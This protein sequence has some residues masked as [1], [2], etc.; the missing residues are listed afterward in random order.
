MQ[1]DPISMD[2]FSTSTGNLRDLLEAKVSEC[3]AVICLIGRAFGEPLPATPGIH[4]RSYTQFEFDLAQRFGIPTFLFIKKF[5]GNAKDSLILEHPHQTSFL[6]EIEMSGLVRHPFSNED[7]FR[8]HI[9]GINLESIKLKKKEQSTLPPK[10]RSLIKY[11][12]VI[13]LIL[14]LGC[15]LFP[16]LLRQASS[17]IQPQKAK[18]SSQL[19]GIVTDIAHPQ[20]ITQSPS[21]NV[22][23]ITYEPGKSAR[24]KLSEGVYKEFAWCPPGSF[25]MGFST[26]EAGSNAE[27]RI[28]APS[29]QVVFVE[30]FWIA[31][32]ELTYDEVNAFINIDG[33][34]FPESA[35]KS[36]NTKGIPLHGIS[37]NDAIQL[38]DWLKRQQEGQLEISL[39][40]ECE[41]EYAARAG[42]I[43]PYSFGFE[44]DGTQANC[45]GRS[46][47][48]SALNARLAAG[49]SLNQPVQTGSYPAN[50]WGIYDMHGNV[51]EWALDFYSRG[52]V[53]SAT[54]QLPSGPTSGSYHVLR[55]G[56]WNSVARSCRSASR[57]RGLPSKSIEGAGIRLVARPKAFK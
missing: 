13:F 9:L 41:W 39:P 25:T 11:L 20:T 35:L 40:L 3:D 48:F 57:D 2:H 36:F 28:D 7:E 15:T 54:D 47:P 16:F 8:R 42:T 32:H 52:Y 29:Q 34:Q 26:D 24:I 23:S 43:T 22:E 53:T 14:A 46:A 49:T 10:P 6:H 18:L 27:D 37:Y 55:G 5:D 12:G 17:G 30:G 19:T 33:F 4:K 44:L 38:T 51:K 50:P 1:C 45:D 21:P 31:K 56:Y